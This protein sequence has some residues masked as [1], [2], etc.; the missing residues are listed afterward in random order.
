MLK[1]AFLLHRIVLEI[2]I[3]KSIVLKKDKKIRYL[4][5]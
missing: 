2:K 1:T 5:N 4:C 3:I